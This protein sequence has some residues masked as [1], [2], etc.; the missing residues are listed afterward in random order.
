MLQTMT[1]K[2]CVLTVDRIEGETAVVEIGGRRVDVP[3]AGLPDGTREGDIFAL[4]PI[5]DKNARDEDASRLQRLKTRA[6][7][8]PGTFDL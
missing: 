1:P 4:V 5:D 2:K 3:L 6:K 8:G 7:Q